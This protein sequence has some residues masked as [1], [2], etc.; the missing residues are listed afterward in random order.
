MTADEEWAMDLQLTLHRILTAPTPAA[1]WE[2]YGTLLAAGAEEP[3]LETVTAFHDYLS[4]L[5][6][7]ATARQFSE[8]ASLLD[9]GAVGGVALQNLVGTGREAD[10][11]RDLLNRFLLGTAS[12][13]L[14][15]AASRQYIKA[16]QA[17]LHAVH[18]QAA[19]FLAGALWRLAGAGGGLAAGE[20]WARIEGLLAPAR[21]PAVANEEKAL[22]LGRTFQLVLLS[23][24]IDLAQGAGEAAR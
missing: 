20:R 14:M 5:Q 8:I 19:W 17:E 22:L 7:K 23:R 1:L 4:D 12:E 21:D 9:I 10:G 3:L 2:L 18:C 13:S 15:V 16:W 11:G 6:S 24:L